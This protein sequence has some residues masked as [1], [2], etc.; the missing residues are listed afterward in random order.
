MHP[1]LPSVRPVAAIACR[2]SE[3]V[4]RARR[5]EVEDEARLLAVAGS[6]G[7]TLA[8][9]ARAGELDLTVDTRRRL[10]ATSM[11]VSLGRDTSLRM[12]AALH[13]AGVP[14]SRAIVIK[15]GAIAL[16]RPSDAHRAVAD[17]DV[18]VAESDVTAWLEAAVRIG[19]SVRRTTGYEVAYITRERG[20]IELHIALPGFAG[21]DAGPGWESIHPRAH[22]PEGQPWLVPDPPIAR[23]IAVQHFLFHHGGEAGHALR[24]L[25]DL[26]LLD[27]GGEGDGLDWGNP[28]VA[29]A[30]AR[31][32]EIARAIR[33]G[34]DGD[35]AADAFLSNLA[36]IVGEQTFR[37]FAEESRHWIVQ[38]QGAW[39]RIALL[40]RRL[41][42]PVGEMRR[43][44]DDTRLTIA[45]R[46]ARRPF[47]LLGKYRAASR[48]DRARGNA[49][50]QWRA[51]IERLAK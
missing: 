33:D 1:S 48:A 43:A 50:G 10:A 6:L 17:V 18:V 8:L 12:L 25:Q 14:S 26:T 30:T 32:R 39:A 4:V 2:A 5:A 13:D 35:P 7:M 28:A 24:T 42:P 23:E 37:S 27:D 40:A 41:A 47:D 15:G 29:R 49:L 31:M 22:H 44:P 19:M 20:L 3:A 11:L 45:A 46:Y 51:E 34:R 9:D 38:K 21:N 36:T 16:A